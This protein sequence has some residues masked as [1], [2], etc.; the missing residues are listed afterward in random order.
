MS[1]FHNL[2][3]PGP[4]VQRAFIDVLFS[5]ED[6]VAQ[7]IAQVVLVHFDIDSEASR[8][9]FEDHLSTDGWAHQCQSVVGLSNATWRLNPVLKLGSLNTK[10]A[11][12][13]F[14]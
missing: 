1:C 12:V 11:E 6:C 3:L 10:T 14:A 9:D 7:A 4:S 2:K 13:L 5:Y 8:Q